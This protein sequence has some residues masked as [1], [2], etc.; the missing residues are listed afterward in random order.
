[1]MIGL[2]GLTGAGKST[3]ARILEKKGCYIIDG[4]KVG[5]AVTEKKGILGQI[6]AAFGAGVINLDGSLN[7]R[8]LGSIVFSD[9]EALKKLN[10]ITHP[11]IKKAVLTEAAL[12]RGETVVIDGAVIKECG[13]T[14][15]CAKVIRITAPRELRCRRIME[16]DNLTLAEAEKRINA[17]T[18]HPDNWIDV[19]NSSSEE[20]LEQK[21]TEVL[22]EIK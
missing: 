19:D 16:R 7:R 14:D 21:L 13:L 5:H 1:M 3:A 9:G 18:N 20:A 22:C 8:A 10:A 11:E 4:D 6:K 12:H 15:C 17:Q 2:T